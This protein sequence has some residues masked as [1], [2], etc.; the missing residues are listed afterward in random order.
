MILSFS[1]VLWFGFHCGRDRCAQGGRF[2][3]FPL[4][5]PVDLIA[6]QGLKL[7]EDLGEGMELI[8]IFFEDLFGPII[9]ALHDPAD[10]LID[11]DS[12]LFRI[13]LLLDETEM[14]NADLPSGIQEVLYRPLRLAEAVARIKAGAKTKSKV[15]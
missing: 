10:L 6:I 3:L 7:K 8:G 14:K 5:D 1:L 2:N 12:G 9:I 15:V 13:M 11:G 4:Q